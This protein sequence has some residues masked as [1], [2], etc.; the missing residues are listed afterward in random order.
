[1]S[2]KTSSIKLVAGILLA[3][4]LV[5]ENLVQCVAAADPVDPCDPC[6][7]IT[8]TVVPEVARVGDVVIFTIC[9]EGF[10]LDFPYVIR[11]SDP[12]PVEKCLCHFLIDPPDCEACALV[13]IIPPDPNPPE[14]PPEPPTASFTYSPEKPMIGGRIDFD[15]SDS[16]GNIVDYKW[17]FGDGSLTSMASP[18]SNHTYEKPGEYTVTLTVTDNEGLTD[19]AESSFQVQLT[20]GDLLLGEGLKIVPGPWSHIGM[21]IGSGQIVESHKNLGGVSITQL[22][23]WFD[24]YQTWAVLQVVTADDYVREQAVNWATHQDR[25]DDPYDLNWFQKDANGEAW[26]CS[27][28]VWAAYLHASNGQIDIEFEPD[29]FGITPYEIQLDEETEVIAEHYEEAPK[30]GIIIISKCPVD[31]EIVDPDNLSANKRLIEIPGAIYGEDDIDDDGSPD[32]WIG[33]FER[34]TGQYRVKVVPESEVLPTET[35][36]LTVTADS[37]TITLA[38]DVAIEDIPGEPYLIQSTEEGINAVP[39]AEAGPD[40]TVEQED[41][42]GALVTLNGSGSTDADSTPGTNDDILYFDWWEGDVPLWSGEII[43]YPFPPGSYTVTLCVTDSA[44]V[45]DTDEAIIVIEDTTPPEISIDV[46]EP[47][48]LYAVGELTLDFSAY[49]SVSGWLQP[50]DYLWGELK[51]AASDPETVYPGDA[52]GAGVYTLVVSA[53]D[54]AGNAAM[55]DPVFFVVYDPDGGFV[56]GGGWI[57]SPTG[58]YAVNPTL[59]GKANF[60]FVSKYKK[61]VSVPTGNTEFVFQAAGLN[62]HSTSYDW[63]V[64]TGSNYARFKGTGTINGS[65]EYR[66]MLWAGDDAPDTFRIKIW[67][68][69]EFGVEDVVYDNGSDQA[70]GGGSIVVHA[71]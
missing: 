6:V 44:G 31:L 11:S 48:G 62:F 55:S 57:W 70:I 46:P 20:P 10:C 12:D 43:E 61:G 1:M 59:E 60:G 32:D 53:A 19:T 58:A 54:E 50:P 37:D 22:Q 64:V 56:T 9:G 63:L 41:Y 16:K 47:Y 69:D 25:L 27:E 36:N 39:V 28:L 68:E 21:Y 71:K 67:T 29:D 5:N 42:E 13:D 15:A 17:D 40:Q 23:N 38:E 33:I 4:A 65:G 66:F 24:R 18:F 14:T 3:V 7:D 26:Y 45:T 52:P 34:K 2:S 51:D 49:D 30:G 8:M 35:Y